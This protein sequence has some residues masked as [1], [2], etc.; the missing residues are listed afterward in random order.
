MKN[1]FYLFIFAAV[2]GVFCPQGAFAQDYYG[3]IGSQKMETKVN[4]SHILVKDKTQAQEL[5]TRIDKGEKFEDLAKE[6][7]MCPSGQNGGDLGYFGRGQMV[8]EFEDAA[9]ATPVNSVSEPVQTQ[10]GW[11]LIKVID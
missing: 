1:L 11:H 3:S 10:F 6:Y 8:K 5:K 4:A 2:L 7:S 9:F